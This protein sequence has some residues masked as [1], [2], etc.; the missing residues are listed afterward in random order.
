MIEA[1]FTQHKINHFKMYNSV[2]LSTFTKLFNHH[3]FL[4][5]KHSYLPK[6][7]TQNYHTATPCY[8]I[9]LIIKCLATTNLLLSLWM[10]DI[11]H[12]NGII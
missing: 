5:L 11:H 8:P 9:L 1:K 6:V 2:S 3:L 7:K 4:V 12:T 10:Y